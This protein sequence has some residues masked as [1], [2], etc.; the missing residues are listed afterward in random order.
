MQIKRG[1]DE[2]LHPNCQAYKYR[3]VAQTCGGLASHVDLIF[4]LN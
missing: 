3:R 4:V 2:A 1:L